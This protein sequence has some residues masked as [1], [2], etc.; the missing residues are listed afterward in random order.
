[1]INLVKMV[2][3]S[4]KIA[5]DRKIATSVSNYFKTNDKYLE[6]IL[7]TFSDLLS[8]SIGE[9]LKAQIDIFKR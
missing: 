1:I 4:Y 5:Y 9:D 8:M 2:T 3:D 6:N 7:N